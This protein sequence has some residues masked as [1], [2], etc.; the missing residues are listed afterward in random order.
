MRGVLED[1]PARYEPFN[2]FAVDGE[3]GHHMDLEVE[4]LAHGHE[5]GDVALAVAAEPVVRPYDPG[6]SPDLFVEDALDEIIGGHLG[7]GDGELDNDE[8]IDA[9]RLDELDFLLVEGDEGRSISGRKHL[10]GMGIEGH[11]QGL[12]ADG[13]GQVPDQ[14]KDPHVPHVDTVKVADGE[15]RIAKGARDVFDTVDHFHG[16]DETLRPA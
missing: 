8:D 16:S 15:N 9:C 4:S 10:D 2:L 11:H 14:V 7:E 3:V 6:A 12:A 5:E 13:A 1:L